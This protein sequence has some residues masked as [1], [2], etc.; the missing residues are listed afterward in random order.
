MS[1]H[2]RHGE[3]GT[4]GRPQADPDD[5]KS[6]GAPPDDAV[7][8]DRPASAQPRVLQGGMNPEVGDLDAEA[9]PDQEPDDDGS[10]PGRMGG[11]LIGG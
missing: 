7:D 10:L 9:D 1:I 4:P 5:D 8:T 3:G 6:S 11:G 2:A